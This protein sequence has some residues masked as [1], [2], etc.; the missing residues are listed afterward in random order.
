MEKC[1]G[2]NRPTDRP[3]LVSAASLAR[4]ASREGSAVFVMVIELVFLFVNLTVA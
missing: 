1:K 4:L 3:S 2:T